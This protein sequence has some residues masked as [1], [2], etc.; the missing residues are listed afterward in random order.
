MKTR[1]FHSEILLP[2]PRETV[3]AFFSDP[4]NLD[5]LTPPW[6]RF[7]IVTPPPIR[8]EVGALVDYR[9]RIRGL[10]VGWRSRIAVWDPPR[11]FVD[12]QVS[13]PYRLW[14][15]EH[16]FEER[17]GGTLVTDRV[18][19]AVPFDFLLHR[20]FV[21]PDIEKIFA[22]RADELARRFGGTRGPR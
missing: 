20:F 5:L 8:M 12:E 19:Y 16:G 6:L 10:P 2:V 4:A 22:F 9:L 7:R 17:D 11:V 3:F 21:R 1:E 18:R 13:G 15:H 14:H